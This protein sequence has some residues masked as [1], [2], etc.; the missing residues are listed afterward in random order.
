MLFP[1]PP[2]GQAVPPAYQTGPRGSRNALQH[3]Q[4]QTRGFRDGKV[5]VPVRTK[6]VHAPNSSLC[7]ESRVSQGPYFLFLGVKNP[8]VFLTFR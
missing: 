4:N 8:L 6:P 2:A 1:V 5:R 7:S 3:V